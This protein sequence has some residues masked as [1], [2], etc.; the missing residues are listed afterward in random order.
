MSQLKYFP[1]AR[2]WIMLFVAVLLQQGIAMAQSK[3]VSGTVKDNNGQP[4][5]G[6]SVQVQNSS[7]LTQ[8]DGDGR[9]SLNVVAAVS[10]Q[11]SQISGG[12]EGG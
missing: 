3:T 2:H 12:A 7:Q 10:G 11:A 1:V 8:A 5:P 4:L 9:F 6:A